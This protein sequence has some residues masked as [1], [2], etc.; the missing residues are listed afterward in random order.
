MMCTALRG[1]APAGGVLCPF[2]FAQRV[3]KTHADHRKE[4][5]SSQTRFA[6]QLPHTAIV[7]NDPC[8]VFTALTRLLRAVNLGGMYFPRIVIE[9]FRVSSLCNGVSWSIK[10]LPWA[11]SRLHSRLSRRDI[12]TGSTF[13]RRYSILLCA[14]VDADEIR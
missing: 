12:L 9:T 1:C 10:R 2:H 3:Q 13:K 14:K 8:L 6:S 11:P 7:T 5:L 4:P